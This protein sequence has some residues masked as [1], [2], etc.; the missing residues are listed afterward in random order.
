[1]QIQRL[2]LIVGQRHQPRFNLFHTAGNVGKLLI[3]FTDV[4]VV[5]RP[6]GRVGDPALIQRSIHGNDVI[7]FAFH[8]RQHVFNGRLGLPLPVK[9]GDTAGQQFTGLGFFSDLG[10]D[11]TDSRL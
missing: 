10:F 11:F 1:M 5:L 6:F 9:A 3:G 4:N 8:L 2:A 7:L